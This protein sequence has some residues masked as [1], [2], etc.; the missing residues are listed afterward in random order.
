MDRSARSSASENELAR[1]SETSQLARA[2]LHCTIAT[3]AIASVATDSTILRRAGTPN[4]IHTAAM[5]SPAMITVAAISDVLR[6]TRP[7][8]NSATIE[9]GVNAAIRSH[10]PPCTAA[11][12]SSTQVPTVK[13]N[14]KIAAVEG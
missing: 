6:R 4:R 9:A 7:C 3:A 1:L 8:W 14:V 13:L 10:H 5:P 12:N 2:G 11:K